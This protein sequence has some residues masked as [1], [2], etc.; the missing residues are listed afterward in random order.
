[1]KSGK[2]ASFALLVL[3]IGAGGCGSTPKLGSMPGS[4]SITITPTS[5]LVGSPD[6]P[7]TITEFNFPFANGPHKSNRAIGSANGSDINLATT[8]NSVNQLIVLIPSAL[9][10]NPITA[11]VRVFGTIKAT[12]LTRPQPLSASQSSPLHPERFRLVRSR[13][14]VRSQ[15]TLI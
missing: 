7:A 11:D 10:S 9:L 5:M 15:A 8:F 1:M 14:R 4:A 12:Y 13:L 3:L 6:T 2:T